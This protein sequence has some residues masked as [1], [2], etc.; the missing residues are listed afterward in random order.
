M[1]PCAAPHPTS[2]NS[3]GAAVGLAG[4]LLALWPG[5]GGLADPVGALLMVSAGLG[6]AAYTIVGRRSADPLAANI[7]QFSSVPATV[8]D[9]IAR[10][11]PVLQRDRSCA[12]RFVRVELHQ[13][14]GYALW[15]SVLPRLSQS[16]AACCSVKCTCH[17]HPCRFVGFGRTAGNYHCD[18]CGTCGRPESV[19]PSAHD[20][21]KRVIA[22][23]GCPEG[24]FSE[25]IRLYSE[26]VHLD[27]SQP[28]AFGSQYPRHHANP[29]PLSL[30]P[31]TEHRKYTS[32]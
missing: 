14:L 27:A 24:Y 12:W 26:R 20:H 3:P 18:F 7:C 21:L 9:P 11:V 22:D 16:T 32:T 5:P 15:Y 25:A 17:C 13:G 2:G 6:W 19:G 28:S 4:L 10:I 29:G 23:P 8:V 1:G 31:I 30:K